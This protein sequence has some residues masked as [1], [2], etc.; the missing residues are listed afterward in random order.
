MIDKKVP[1]AEK[2][3]LSKKKIDS[4]PKRGNKEERQRVRMVAMSSW[5]VM[6]GIW[7]ERSKSNT[8]S[9]T[10]H[11]DWIGSKSLDWK[12]KPH[13]QNKLAAQLRRF[14]QSQPQDKLTIPISLKSTYIFSWDLTDISSKGL[15]ISGEESH[16]ITLYEDCGWEPCGKEAIFKNWVNW[17]LWEQKKNIS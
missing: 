5:K 7:K 17:G 10:W 13:P 9:L 1:L 3:G 11:P 2:R 15:I 14:C 4:I 6:G 8:A 16:F 12:Q